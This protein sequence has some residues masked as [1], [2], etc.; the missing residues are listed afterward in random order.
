MSHL[1]CGFPDIATDSV[2]SRLET[3]IL[4]SSAFLDTLS[5]HDASAVKEMVVSV[6][7]L[8]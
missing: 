8:L 7:D 1:I 5:P 3:N 6:E 4:P 2:T